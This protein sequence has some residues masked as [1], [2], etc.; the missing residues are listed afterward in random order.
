MVVRVSKK[1]QVNEGIKNSFVFYLTNTIIQLKNGKNRQSNSTKQLEKLILLS[2]FVL[3]F[4]EIIAG[5]L[6]LA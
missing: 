3:R 4:F 2:L 1:K 6:P 5:F